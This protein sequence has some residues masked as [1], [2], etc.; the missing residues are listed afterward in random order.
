MDRSEFFVEGRKC[1]LTEIRRRKLSELEQ[2]M[3][4]NDEKDI[5]S[6]SEVECF[7]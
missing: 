4:I 2:Y 5:A 6:M 3:R 1:P 7:K